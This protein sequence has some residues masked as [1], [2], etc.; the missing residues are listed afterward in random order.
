M[1]LFSFSVCLI[2]HCNI[3]KIVTSF[4]SINYYDHNNMNNIDDNYK[5]L[6]FIQSPD[7]KHVADIYNRLS[8]LSPILI[9][10]HDTIFVVN[11]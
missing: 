6:T 4:Y 11:L 2:F 8:G 9:E 1:N 10:G 3:F 5:L 7:A